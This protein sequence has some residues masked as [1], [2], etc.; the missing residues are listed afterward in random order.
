MNTPQFEFL[1]SKDYKC[2]GCGY[3]GKTYGYQKGDKLLMETFDPCEEC[4]SLDFDILISV[5]NI[6]RFDERFPYFDRGLGVTL[7]SKKHR[8][9]VCKERGVVPIDGDVNI[10][11]DIGKIKRKIEE[12]D[13]IVKDL[14]EKVEHHPGY[15]EYRKQKD[16]G[17][18]PEFKHREQSSAPKVDPFDEDK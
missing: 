8:D 2:K 5:P 18:K 16:Q 14:Q 11:D 13:K 17:W 7:Q 1:T 9:E 4:E 6:D 12:E 15:A 3:V 10:S